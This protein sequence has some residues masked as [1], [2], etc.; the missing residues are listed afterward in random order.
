MMDSSFLV[1]EMLGIGNLGLRKT[2]EVAFSPIA[3]R[4]FGRAGFHTR[5]AAAWEPPLLQTGWPGSPARAAS[6]VP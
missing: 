6:Q 2:I 3:Y 4:A 5:P 1:L